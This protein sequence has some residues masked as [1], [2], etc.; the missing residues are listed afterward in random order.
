MGIL[1]QH[2]L[3]LALFVAPLNEAREYTHSITNGAA[4]GSGDVL[5]HSCKVQAENGVSSLIVTIAAE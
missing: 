3:A 2:P 4:I 1:G 5:I